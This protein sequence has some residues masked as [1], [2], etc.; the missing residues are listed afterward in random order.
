MTVRLNF[1]S[2]FLKIGQKMTFDMHPWKI[3]HD[4]LLFFLNDLETHCVSD[5]LCQFE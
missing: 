2:A 3:L 5:V 1:L 4:N